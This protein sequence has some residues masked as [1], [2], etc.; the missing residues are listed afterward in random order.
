MKDIVIQH[1]HSDIERTSELRTNNL[2]RHL[3]FISNYINSLDKST[4][5]RLIALLTRNH[6]LPIETDRWQ[7]I[8]SYERTCIFNCNDMGDE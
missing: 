3:V 1:W 7:N 2:K 6:R 8:P 5:N 4:C